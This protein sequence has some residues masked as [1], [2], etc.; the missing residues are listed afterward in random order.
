MNTKEMLNKIMSDREKMRIENESLR[1]TV[2]MLENK[3][4][5]SGSGHSKNDEIS[6]EIDENGDK[7]DTFTPK[8]EEQL[9]AARAASSLLDGMPTLHGIGSVDL[10]MAEEA[11]FEKW[12]RR[13]EK[14]LTGSRVKVF[15]GTRWVTWKQMFLQEVAL[16]QLQEIL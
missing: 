6:A 10:P 7:G 2:N 16:N 4:A 5:A 15:N 14:S 3:S 8:L 1:K 9:K 13:T 11:V 12:Y